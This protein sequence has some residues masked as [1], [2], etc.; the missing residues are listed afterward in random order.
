M[1]KK[2][3]MR[4]SGHLSRVSK[5]FPVSHHFPLCTD[6]VCKLDLILSHPVFQKSHTTWAEVYEKNEH[7]ATFDNQLNELERIKI[8]LVRHLGK[9]EAFYQN[10]LSKLFGISHE[11]L[12]NGWITDLSND[13]IL[14]EIKNVKHLR[15]AIGQIIQY[16]TFR[17]K[18]KKIICLFGTLPNETTMQANVKVCEKLNIDLIWL[19]CE[20][21]FMWMKEK[22]V[23]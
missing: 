2:T 11:Y 23:F 21:I 15:E 18:A 10:N 8:K 16:S 5:Y 17:P 4:L 20:E 19:Y 1:Q 3:F 7:F 14:I 9:T 13:D 12:A 22:A 6:T